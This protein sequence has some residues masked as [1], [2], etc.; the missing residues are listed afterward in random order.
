MI[1]ELALSAALS[2]GGPDGYDAQLRQLQSR[3]RKDGYDISAIL[4]RPEFEIYV[5]VERSKGKPRYIN[6]ADTTQSWYMR[7]DS[8]ESCADFLEEE[9]KFLMEL[10]REYG[11]SAEQCSM[12]SQYELE[13]NRGNFKGNHIAFNALV[14]KYLHRTGRSRERFYQYLK[15]FLDVAT[16]TTDNIILSKNIL[17]IM[18]S[19]A[20]AIGDVQT[21]GYI[22]LKYGK[23]G[24]GD[25]RIDPNNRYDALTTLA[26]FR[27]QNGGDEDLQKAIHL[28]NPGHPF[29][30][31]SITM[32]TVELKKIR[33]DRER[34]FIRNMKR[35]P[36]ILGTIPV[37]KK[38]AALHKTKLKPQPVYNR[39][40]KRLFMRQE[41]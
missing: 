40:G 7:R 38:D 29:Y 37:P 31:P 3:L 13:T 20:G 12:V 8:V 1:C 19:H 2:F 26:N 36:S 41:R 11:P 10:E 14:S 27:K 28:Y 32:H 35:V 6:Y 18:S 16:D 23:D 21:M 30:Q 17:E 15:D 25:G 39:K 4:E 9:R 34:E 22:L 5:P 33:N 24:S